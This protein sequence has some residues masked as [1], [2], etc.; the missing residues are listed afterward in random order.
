VHFHGVLGPGDRR[1]LGG[2]ERSLRRG[3]VEASLPALT[4][5]NL[6]EQCEAVGIVAADVVGDVVDVVDG[7]VD[8]VVGDDV[9]VDDVDGVV[10]AVGVVGVGVGVVDVGD[11]DDVVVLH[12][13]DVV[14]LD[15]KDVVVVLEIDG[16]DGDVVLVAVLVLVGGSDLVLDGV[17]LG[18]VLDFDL[19]DRLDNNEVVLDVLLVEIPLLV[20]VLDKDLDLVL[21][22]DVVLLPASKVVG[23]T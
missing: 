11:G 4:L 12:A 2:F 9:V 23:K 3:V 8:G 16:E 5:H 13:V 19:V 20:L 6:E 1:Q 21:V 18:D 17:A 15:D 10:G 22:L 7:V 14:D